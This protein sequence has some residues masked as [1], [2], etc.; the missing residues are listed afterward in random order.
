MFAWIKNSRIISFEGVADFLSAT[1][2][3]EKLKNLNF[4]VLRRQA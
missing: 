2:L 4:A 3:K 1:I